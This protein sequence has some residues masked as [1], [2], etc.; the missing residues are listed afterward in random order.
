MPTDGGRRSLRVERH[1]NATAKQTFHHEPTSVPVARMPTTPRHMLQC[2]AHPP[3]PISTRFPLYWLIKGRTSLLHPPNLHG[4]VMTGGSM[5]HLHSPI[6]DTCNLPS[7][8]SL[9]PG[10]LHAKRKTQLV[11]GSAAQQNIQ[12]IAC[13]LPRCLFPPSLLRL[14]GENKYLAHAALSDQPNLTPPCHTQTLLADH[15]QATSFN[16]IVLSSA[17]YTYRIH[18]L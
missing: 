5:S 1:S 16:I 14:F 12:D 18:I 2:A 17:H 10:P 15:P 3:S 6:Q 4:A 13:L 9:A 11:P 8:A 7:P